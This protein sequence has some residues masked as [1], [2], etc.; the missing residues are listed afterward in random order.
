MACLVAF[1]TRSILPPFASLYKLPHMVKADDRGGKGCK[2]I[3]LMETNR[4]SYG[5]ER[6]AT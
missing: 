3:K 6:V 4:V 1:F 5:V 2:N